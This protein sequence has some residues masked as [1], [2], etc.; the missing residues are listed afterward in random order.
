MAKYA[1][2]E[3]SS[4]SR[5]KKCFMTRLIVGGWRITNL[6]VSMYKTKLI[7]DDA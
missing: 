5:A 7:M 4:I 2:R 1:P 6:F 3:V